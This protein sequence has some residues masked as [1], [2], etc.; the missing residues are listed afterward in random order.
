MG[1]LEGEYSL[2]NTSKSLL[3]AVVSIKHLI[4]DYISQGFALGWG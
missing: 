3:E 4:A 2:L 1:N